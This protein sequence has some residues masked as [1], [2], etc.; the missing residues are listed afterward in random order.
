MADITPLKVAAAQSVAA[1]VAV[2]VAHIQRTTKPRTV[3]TL[4]SAIHSLFRK[5]LTEAQLQAVLSGLR[6]EGFVTID[7]SKVVYALA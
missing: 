6:S 7:G 4:T 1:Q 2:V 3:K 5:Q